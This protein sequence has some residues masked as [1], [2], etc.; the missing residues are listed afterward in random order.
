MNAQVRSIQSISGLKLRVWRLEYS[1]PAMN[2]QAINTNNNINDISE[3]LAI[4]HE[5]P[6]GFFKKRMTI[7]RTPEGSR[8][9]GS[10]SISQGD[11]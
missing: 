4:F 2:A 6:H 1:M 7:V 9:V 8:T 5:D 3:E 11:I 10:S